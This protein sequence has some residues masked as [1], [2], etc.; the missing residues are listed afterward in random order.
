MEKTSRMTTKFSCEFCK[1]EYVKEISLINH[2]C[3]KK[4]R[5]FAKDEAY[6]RTAFIAWN[7]FHELNT[8]SRKTNPP[9]AYK[10]FID[11][12]YYNGFIKFGKHIRDIGAIEPAK[13]IDY[14]IKN[15][16]PLDKW[17]NEF[18]YEQYV[19]ELTKQETPDNALMR[20]IMLM[21]EWHMQTGELWYD[22]FR[23][24]NTNQA[25][26]WIKNGRLSPWVIY[27]VDSA[28]EFFIRCT[29]EQ[30]NMITKYAPI[31]LWKLKFDKD[32]ESCDF[33]R[34]TLQ[35]SGM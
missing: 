18:V 29:T 19:R 10:D 27:N 11:S 30:V 14:V 15:N 22:F 1:R 2:S 23:K 31:G 16:L 17:T 4:Q 35:D 6:S 8:P 25:M 3:E 32:Q 9:N 7:R 24:V 12:Q 20:N 13:F 21:K 33:I 28:N 34:T 5:W 26:S